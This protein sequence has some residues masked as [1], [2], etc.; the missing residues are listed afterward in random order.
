MSMII[1]HYGGFINHVRLSYLTNIT[2]NGTTAYDIVEA[3]K[4][5]GFNSYGIRYDLNKHAAKINLPAIAHTVINKSYN[6]FV[7]I[8][9]IN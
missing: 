6:H 5:L 9:E 7:V 2:K 4:A 1:K 8:Y 3:F